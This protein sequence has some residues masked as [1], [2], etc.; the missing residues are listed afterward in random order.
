MQ[1]FYNYVIFIRLSKIVERNLFMVEL[2]KGSLLVVLQ[3]VVEE[4]IVN[5]VKRFFKL[6]D[7][8]RI[9]DIIL[10]VWL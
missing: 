7:F 2:M 4:I 8:V 6:E 5:I 9:Y 3:N 10:Q 1:F